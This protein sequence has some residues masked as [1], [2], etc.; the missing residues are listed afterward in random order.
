MPNLIKDI[1]KTMVKKGITKELIEEF[2]F[3]E[4]N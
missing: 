2:N 3:P 4:K 1:E